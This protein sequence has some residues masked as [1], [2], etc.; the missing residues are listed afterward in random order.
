ML[1]KEENPQGVNGL[2]GQQAGLREQPKP[3]DVALAAKETHLLPPEAIESRFGLSGNE[4]MAI[5]AMGTVT[6]GM[7]GTGLLCATRESVSIGI[8]CLADGFA[9]G[10][11]TPCGLL[12]RFKSHPSIAPASSAPRSRNTPRARSRRAAATRCRN[13]S[14]TPGIW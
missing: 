5:E 13:W 11:E 2:A 4:A 1:T 7:T 6:K 10:Q 3:K 14:A 9:K 12:D 8:G